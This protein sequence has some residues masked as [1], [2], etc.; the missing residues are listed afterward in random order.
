MSNVP[1]IT[2]NDG[3]EIPQLGFGT[4]QIPAE[5]TAEVVAKAL[6][7]GYRHI[8][9]AE[10]YG[11]E[12]GVA[13]GLRE[14]GIGRDEVFIT[15]KLANSDHD[16]DA[17]RRALETTLEKLGTRHLD[18]FLIHWPLPTRDDTDFVQ[19]WKAMESFK[20]EGLTDSIGVSNFQTHHLDELEEQC[21]VTP[22]VN[23]IEIHPYLLNHAVA[24]YGESLGITT[25]A[26]SPLASG[27]LIGEPELEQIAERH[28]KTVP[29]V[30]LRWHIQKGYVIFPKSVTP[31]RIEENFQIF[32]F[33][34]SDEEIGEVEDLDKGEDGR[35]GPNPDTF[36]DVGS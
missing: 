16:P 1:K 14:A 5:D 9:T 19:T 34:L 15:S 23:Q 17:A 3:N 20:A 8:D 26:W 30:V 35:T 18:L 28:G 25:E 2:L 24:A 11:N 29:Q 31:E 21:D 22:A 7:V 36:A 33:E 6:E 32:D 12:Q 27:E 13:D 4:W 10:M